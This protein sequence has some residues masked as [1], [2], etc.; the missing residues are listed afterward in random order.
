MIKS[1]NKFFESVDDLSIEERQ[2]IADVLITMRDLGFSFEIHPNNLNSESG[3]WTYKCE[4]DKNFINVGKQL[5][6]M[7]ETIHWVNE[8][9]LEYLNCIQRLESMGYDVSYTLLQSTYHRNFTSVSYKFDI[10]KKV[11]G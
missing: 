9:S 6:V 2:E 3:K 11:V 10:E 7:E 8:A 5:S 4:G 1:F